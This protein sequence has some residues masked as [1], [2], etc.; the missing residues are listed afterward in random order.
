MKSSPT[1]PNAR[2]SVEATEEIIVESSPAL[3]VNNATHL[4]SEL[5]PSCLGSSRKIV[6]E[7]LGINDILQSHSTR[8]TQPPVAV[9]YSHPSHSGRITIGSRIERSISPLLP[10]NELWII[11]RPL[12]V[13][14]IF[15]LLFRMKVR[16]S[17]RTITL[18]RQTIR[19]RFIAGSNHHVSKVSL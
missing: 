18:G 14:S 3:D 2:L 19:W 5:P 6:G 8:R 17:M 7:N 12:P 4:S 16:Q 13:S 15:T 9:F 1:Q 10:A 11:N